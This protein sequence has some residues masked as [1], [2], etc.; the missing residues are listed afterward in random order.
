MM[1]KKV[2]FVYDFKLPNGF[3]QFGYTKY[4]L[5]INVIHQ[6]DNNLNHPGVLLSTPDNPSEYTIQ[7]GMFADEF[8]NHNQNWNKIGI[9]EVG[10]IVESNRYRETEC[11][12]IVVL[13]STN[14]T[15]FFD[16]YLN[17][18]LNFKHLFSPKLLQYIKEHDNF[19]ILMMDNRE[20]SYEHKPNLLNKAID[21]LNQENIKGKRKFVIST[22]NEH[23]NKFKTLPSLSDNRVYVYNNDF[24]VYKSGQFIVETEERSNSI[25]EN[26]YNYS[27][28]QNLIFDEKEK[29]YLMY[30]RNSARLHRPYFVNKLFKNNLLDKGIISLFKTDDFDEQLKS[31]NND[32]NLNISKA[33]WNEWDEYIDKWYPL[34]IDN[35][36]EEEVAWYHNFLS[37]KDEYEKT[38]F[39]IVSE[40]N[41]ES[42][43]LFITEK[44]LKP[45]MNLH[46]FF[47]NGNPGII[48]HLKK[49]GFQ[50]FDKWW[51]ESYDNEQDFKKR[52]DMVMK[53]VKLVCN[54]SKSEM[55]D[56]VKE[57]QPI[58]QYN[59]SLLK[60][61]FVSKKFEKNLLNVFNTQMI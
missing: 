33:D 10:S 7:D 18:T 56:M 3:L 19:K 51:D 1:N 25:L 47:I 40:T 50:T 30:N 23:I 38:Y 31:K 12:F 13:E 16:Y 6:V 11:I 55:I 60:Q 29:Y 15:N 58:L 44:T 52:T 61:K 14:A 37:R 32:G 22:C 42:N 21:F 48:A 27:L 9:N 17:P 46:P 8:I 2:Y 53:Q 20:G 36:N 57:M 49:L 59:K 24:Y 4:T 41:A 39:S 45:I 26:G 35:G 43:Y 54:K 28:Q 34:I 5:P